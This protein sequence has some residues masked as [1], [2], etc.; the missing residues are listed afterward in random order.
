MISRLRRNTLVALIL[1]FASTVM[2]PVLAGDSP[3]YTT[4]KIADGVYLF[5]SGAHRS[6]FLVGDTGVIVT[7]PVN[8]AVAVAYREAISGITPLAVKYVVYSHYHW[9]RIAGGQ[10]FR[11]E[12][13]RFVAQERC[14][15]RLKVYPNPDVIVP[16]ITFTNRL[17]V[18]AGNMELR[19]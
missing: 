15:E 16:E 12:G 14:A 4:D 13:A 8:P 6:L 11:D 17:S 9:D 5:N 19:I 1:G 18:S 10:V 2:D 7:D 3:S